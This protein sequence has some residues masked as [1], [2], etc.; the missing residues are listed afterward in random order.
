MEVKLWFCP[1]YG[2]IACNHGGKAGAQHF[3]AFLRLRAVFV[4]NIACKGYAVGL[5]HFWQAA[6][7][8]R[9]L[10]S[11]KAICFNHQ[12]NLGYLRIYKR[13]HAGFA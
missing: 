5:L 12:F 2:R 3:S 10:H 7:H 11:M 8:G 4:V 6:D 9:Q 1:H 13:L